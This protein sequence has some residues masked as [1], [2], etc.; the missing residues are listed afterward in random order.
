MST[1]RY[2]AFGDHLTADFKAQFLAVVSRPAIASASRL[3]A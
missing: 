3:S 2:A 1:D